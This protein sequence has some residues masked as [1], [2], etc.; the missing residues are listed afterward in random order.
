MTLYYTS[1]GGERINRRNES[2]L[3]VYLFIYLFERHNILQEDCLQ[4]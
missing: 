2:V 4:D 1:Y 3:Y